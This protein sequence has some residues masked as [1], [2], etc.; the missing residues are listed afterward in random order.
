[1]YFPEVKSYY[2]FDISKVLS[3]PKYQG[4]I[5]MGPWARGVKERGWS[6]TPVDVFYQ[7]NPDLSLGHK[8]Y[9]GLFLS[10]SYGPKGNPILGDLYICDATSCFSEPINGIVADDGEVVMSRWRHDERYSADDSVWIDGG[11]DYLRC[12]IYSDERH[13]KVTVDGRNYVVK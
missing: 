7:P 5:F 12:G 4:A 3:V 13:A 10:L 9:F 1:M 6:E 11:R 8:N 2:G